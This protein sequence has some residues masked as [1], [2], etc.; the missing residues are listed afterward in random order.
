MQ[1]QGGGG[2]GRALRCALAAAGLIS[3]LSAVGT[4][5]LLAQWRELSAA[6]RELQA[7]ARQLRGPPSSGG[8]A[9]AL[10][11][12]L[13][14]TA[15]ADG[16]VPAAGRAKRSQQRRRG[17]AKGHLRAESEDMLMLMTYSMVPVGAR[18]GGH[19]GGEACG[20]VPGLTSGARSWCVSVCLF[21]SGF[22]LTLHLS[23]GRQLPTLPSL[24]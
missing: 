10:R 23:G 9:A 8:P 21:E 7:E 2:A 1:G 22:P 20:G 17:L 6:L 18:W 14:P 11:A 4:L 3:A 24:E 13:A 12:A 5:F 19:G 16:A 15:S